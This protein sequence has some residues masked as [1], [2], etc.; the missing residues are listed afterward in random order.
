METNP[1]DS[2]EQEH[3]PALHTLFPLETIVKAQLL[4]AR[5]A[6]PST[7][8]DL[9]AALNDVH[10]PGPDHALARG[11]QGAEGFAEFI[12]GFDGHV[13]PFLQRGAVGRAVVGFRDDALLGLFDPC[14]RFE[15]AVVVLVMDSIFGGEGRYFKACL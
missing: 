10:E 6:R 11:V 5:I 15:C 9:E 4:Q 12:A 3:A 13:A 7:N 8:G 14:A 2:C 1:K